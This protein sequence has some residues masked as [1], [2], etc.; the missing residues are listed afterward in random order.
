[1]PLGVTIKLRLETNRRTGKICYKESSENNHKR[2]NFTITKIKI[3]FYEKTD[4]NI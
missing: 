1:M 2:Y 3:N 4:N